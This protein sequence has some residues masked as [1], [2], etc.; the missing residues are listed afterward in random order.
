MLTRTRLSIIAGVAALAFVGTG[1][2]ALADTGWGSTDCGQIPTPAC[3]LEAG[4][5]GGGGSPGGSSGHGGSPQRPGGGAGGGGQGGSGDTSSGSGNSVAECRYVRSDFQP[6]AGGVISTAY[7]P[8]TAP[9]GVVQAAMVRPAVAR[10][11]QQGEGAWYMWTCDGEGV[12]HG[13]YRPP[14]WMADGQAPGEALLP[15]PAELS[16][17]ARRQLR[18]PSPAI[19]ASPAADQLVNLP[20]WMWLTGSWRPV[21]ATASVPGVSVTAVATPTSV[22]WVMGDGTT[23]TCSGPGTPY[24]AGADPTAASPTCGHVYRRS[25]TSLPGQAYAVSATVHWRI[26]WSGAGQGGTF[27]DMTTTGTAAFRVAESQVLNNGGG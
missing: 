24:Q 17:V 1:L 15:S 8:S 6:P 22:S 21:S 26:S 20:T 27:P 4:S 14:V 18:L 12:A 13:L 9:G 25:S 19:A 16:R 7:R 5:N 3:E 23:V 11:A 2:P 10:A